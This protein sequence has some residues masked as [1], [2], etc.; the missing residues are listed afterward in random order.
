MLSSWLQDVSYSFRLL[1]KSPGFYFVVITTI[2]IGI[3]INAGAFNLFNALLLRPLPVPDS[4]SV[5]RVYRAVPGEAEY[6]PF[7]YPDYV[8]FR[9]QL[10]GQADLAAY[11][12]V[13]LI[14][15]GRPDE[16]SSDSAASVQEN[17]EI[18]GLLVSDSYFSVLQARTI[19]GRTFSES[20]GQ[21]ESR[22]PVAV[23]SYGFWQR[24]FGSQPGVLGNSIKLN[25]LPFTVIGVTAPDVV[26]TELQRPDVWVPIGMQERLAG[27][28]A[29]G[30][31]RLHDRK[32]GWLQVVG[33][34]GAGISIKKAQ[35]LV[36]VVAGQLSTAYPDIEGKEKAKV[37]GGTLLTPD[38]ESEFK[39][40]W[41]LVMAATTMLLLI[42]CAN[43]SAMLFARAT[44]RLQE[45]AIRVALGAS[46]S[47][48][49]RQLLTENLIVAFIGGL[50]GVG[51]AALASNI[52]FQLVHPPNEK[53]LLVST[54]PDVGI[55]LYTLGLVVVIGVALGFIPVLQT[56]NPRIFGI[57]KIGGIGSSKPVRRSNIQ[58]VLVVAQ[59]ALCFSLLASAGLL[60]RGLGRAKNTDAGFATK[61]VVTMTLNLRARGY[62]GP[63]AAALRDQIVNR[64]T[65]YPGVTSVSLAS[66]LPLGAHRTLQVI[67][68]EENGARFPTS[69]RTIST[70]S[71]SVNY[72]ETLQLPL[73]R[74][75]T[76]GPEE[77]QG[78]VPGVIVNEAMA[79]RFWSGED[80]LG[81][82]ITA[83]PYPSAPVI[84]VVKD[85]R[86]VQFWEPHRPQLY[87]PMTQVSTTEM[88]LLIRT[89]NS[90]KPLALVLPEV[91][92]GADEGIPTTVALMSDTVA[93]WIW[94]SQI[95]A[96][97][98]IVLGGFAA[99][100]AAMGLY[101]SIAYSISQRVR[102]IGLRM[103]LGAERAGVLLM[104]V[105]QGVSF[106][107]IGIVI[108]ILG[109]LGLIRALSS[110]LYGV[111]PFDPVIFTAVP[112]LVVI[113]AVC[114]SYLPAL[115]ASRI[116]PAVA[117]RYE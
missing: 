103:A 50:V 68:I 21:D 64:L 3:G 98:A 115:Q 46:R 13:P 52:L 59:I 62:S 56:L 38:R 83:S 104:I 36:Q 94:P 102:E 27:A 19:L 8:D 111:S 49:S 29:L 109:S 72:F 110:F 24:R 69:Q 57:L 55:V 63:A 101:G 87:L 39:S 93:Q 51:L 61:G 71:I 116:D 88:N 7:S 6:N 74:G 80:P 48:L 112:M 58:R 40:V 1:R 60:V 113:T 23:L 108:G 41:M 91:V 5:V 105:R 15:E 9:E 44:A 65:A 99:V 82:R 85:S 10:K 81:K 17:E 26:G 20:A 67:G 95:A 14:L 86:S 25:G 78:K 31:D 28:G 70:T 18:D 37:I 45:F 84:G 12:R 32:F 33:R 107:L 117:L 54:K 90:P 34:L 89:Q 2:G 79:Q 66:T 11:S 114:A 16:A 4:K 73:V 92:R 43:V 47:K 42:V 97:L 96:W 35:G 100:L 76:F 75:R 53:A 106:A 77:I 30:G 22:S